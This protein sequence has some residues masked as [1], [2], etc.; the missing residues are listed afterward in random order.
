ML[1]NDDTEIMDRL[2]EIAEELNDIK[3]RA[4]VPRLEALREYLKANEMHKELL[5]G[6]RNEKGELLVEEP[7]EGL[8]AGAVARQSVTSNPC[9]CRSCDRGSNCRFA[10]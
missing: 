1:E 8:P 6:P 10:R 7:T 4:L 5:N 2:Q 9:C 3:G